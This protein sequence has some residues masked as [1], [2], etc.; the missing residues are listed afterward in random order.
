M[1][2]ETIMSAYTKPR[3]NAPFCTFGFKDSHRFIDRSALLALTEPQ[4]EFFNQACCPYVNLTEPYSGTFWQDMKNWITPISNRAKAYPKAHTYREQL[5]RYLLR[6]VTIRAGSWKIIELNKTNGLLRL[7]LTDV[8][9]KHVYSNRV[10]SSPNIPIGHLNVW[11]SPSWM[12]HVTPAPEAPLMV[13]GFLY[14]YVSSRKVRN[15][16]IL[17]VLLIPQH[18]NPRVRRKRPDARCLGVSA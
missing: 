9:L 5:E 13:Q 12:N 11:V 18:T 6:R 15:I 7:V 3:G 17:P 16:G 2:G 1:K 10:G 8:V 14:E 4:Q